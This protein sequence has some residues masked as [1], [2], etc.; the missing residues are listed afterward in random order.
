MTLANAVRLAWRHRR[1]LHKLVF[2]VRAFGPAK[3]LARIRSDLRGLGGVADYA[4]WVADYDTL[5]PADL[6]AV[7]ALV[8]ALAERPL[9]SLVLT[10]DG[11]RQPSL[12]SLRQQVYPHW[13]LCDAV[14]AAAG[15]FVGVLAAGDE[16]APHALA[17]IAAEIAAHAE[18]DLV[19]GDDD[20]LDAA[21]RRVA[22]RFKPDWDPEL[23]AGLDYLTPFSVV[24]R[25]LAAAAGDGEAGGL[26]VRAAAQARCIRHIPHV[27]YHGRG[28]RAAAAPQAAPPL[29]EPP[30]LVSLLVPTRDGLELVRACV[31]GLLHGTDYPAL[32][33][34]ILDNGSQAPETLAW[35]DDI[36]ADARVRVLPCPGPF[37]FS[38][39][40][41]AGVAAA[42]G[43]VVGFVN[44]DIKVIGPDW[45]RQ[46]VAQASRP[47]IGAVGAKLLYGDGTVQHGGVT[48]G[49]GG[50]AAHA[51][52]GFPGDHPGDMERLRLT[53]SVAA[54][55][56][57]CLVMRKS[58]FAEVGGFD[59]EHLAVAFNDVDL[60]LKLGA[61]GYRIVWT[62]RA[63][64]YHLESVSRGGDLDAGKRERF[65]AETLAMRRRW[66]PL[67]DADPFYNPNLT[68]H[69]GDFAPA[70]PPRRP[71]PW[72]SGG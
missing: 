11:D 1:D 13:Q 34:L 14:A 62:P 31:D 71:L 64:L 68:L 69:A 21:G 61:R 59:A 44:N 67:L 40:N 42:R 41:N 54:V 50:V 10:G 72:R 28:P 4:A 38:A 17:L 53:R 23:L 70:F 33:V 25:G 12:V 26:A 5:G 49:I 19:Y 52:R 3:A 30:P 58:L 32:E 20:R 15:D 46:M 18:A 36:Q 9:I 57:A 6:A 48:L 56:A 27:L 51:H 35:F 66:G 7:Q 37:N 2:Y 29:P 55:T 39:I 43:S 8:D 65:R 60:C 16:L 63:E 24:R 47:E 22:P 45:L